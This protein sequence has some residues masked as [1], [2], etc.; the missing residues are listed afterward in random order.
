M[1]ERFVARVDDRPDDAPWP[2][3]VWPPPVDTALRG[4]DVTLQ[5]VEA[6]RDTEA[7]FAALDHDAVWTHLSGRPDTPEAFAAILRR[8]VDEGERPWVVR[9]AR[10]LAGLDAGKVVGTTSFL[11]VA[12]AHA[13]LEIGWT[14]YT[15]A[16]WGGVVNPECKLLLLGYAFDVLRVG[17]V[18]LKTDVRNVRSQQAIARLGAR[19]EGVLRRY[20]RR[21]DG[22]VRDTV[23]FSITAEDWP[24]VR[25]GLAARLSADIPADFPADGP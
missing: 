14:S 20:Q 8:R 10:P 5:L 11:E 24:V 1:V 21:S 2:H 4:A 16:V 13:R 18:Q 12:P 3:M 19:Y 25:A 17:R 22:T 23:L 9:L 15:P 7:L 6:E